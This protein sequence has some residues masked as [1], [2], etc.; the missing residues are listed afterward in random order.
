MRFL[1]STHYLGVLFFSLR[2]LLYQIAALHLYGFSLMFF[3]LWIPFACLAS[4]NLTYV[5]CI[6]LQ[7]V[8]NQRHAS[9]WLS[10]HRTKTHV[11]QNPD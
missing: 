9:R 8:D 2:V 5:L 7:C 3:V 10:T 11:Q 6:I 1:C 4:I